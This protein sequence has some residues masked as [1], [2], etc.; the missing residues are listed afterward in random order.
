[1]NNTLSLKLAY[2]YLKIKF[3][4]NDFIYDLSLDGF[5]FGLGI[6]F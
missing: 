3:N 5:L 4:D 2:R 6:R 1:M